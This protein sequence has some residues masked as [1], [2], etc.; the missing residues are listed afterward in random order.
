[1]DGLL[2]PFR[3]ILRAFNRRESANDRV[4]QMRDIRD[5]QAPV[6]I[7][8]SSHTTH[9]NQTEEAEIGRRKREAADAVWEAIQE[10]KN[11]RPT[12]V[13]LMDLAHPNNE[14]QSLERWPNF[15][16]AMESLRRQHSKYEDM[17]SVFDAEAK[18]KIHHPH[19][20]DRLWDLFKAYQ[21][22]M[23]RPA[24]LLLEE[25]NSVPANRWWEDDLIKECLSKTT[26]PKEIQQLT[27]SE[28]SPLLK[29]LNGIEEEIRI[30]VQTAR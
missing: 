11:S 22:L 12:A 16:T 2:A 25:P 18:V 26:I 13:F 15:S 3:F 27:N 7:D 24:L 20:T 28:E 6:T 14:I 1:M 17:N 23:A 30:E 8:Q 19:I 10:L 21:L 4:I 29:C 9:L 5:N